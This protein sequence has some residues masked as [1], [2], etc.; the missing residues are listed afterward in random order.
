MQLWANWLEALQFALQ[1]FSSTFGVSAGVAI[2]LLTLTLRLALLPVSWSAAYLGCVHRKKLE[3]LQPELQRLRE[4]FG[5]EPAVLARKTARLYRD[6]N[7]ALVEWR[8]FFGSLAQM[9]VFIGMFQLLRAGANAGKFLWA[10]SL[11]RPDLLL[12]IIAGITTALMIAANPDLPEQ[13]RVILMVLPSVVAILFAMNCASALAL[14]WITSNIFTAAQTA[15]VHFVVGR[16]IRSG[17]I[18]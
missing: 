16:R 9:P 4:R 7:L 5:R 6:R 3:K 2:V 1:F 14:Y 10:S 18:G 17:A 12:A 11:A 13:A 15:T 8:T